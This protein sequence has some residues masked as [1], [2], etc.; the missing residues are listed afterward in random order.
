MRRGASLAPLLLAALAGCPGEPGACP[1]EKQATLT[2]GGAVAAG[3][4]SCAPLIP[5]GAAT[6][7]P[8]TVSFTSD[9]EAALCLSR[10]LVEPRPCSRAGDVLSGCASQAEEVTLPGCPCSISLQE[11]LAGTLVRTEQRVTA[12]TGS[13]LVTLARSTTAAGVACYSAEDARGTTGSCPPAGGC[14]ARYDV[15][16]AP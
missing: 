4:T 5:E 11:T 9:T 6:G 13:L 10:L 12:F 16:G 15:S 7:F 14:S 2:F 3:Q 1:G 8:A